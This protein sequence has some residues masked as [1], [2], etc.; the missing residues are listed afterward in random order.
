M[1]RIST[2]RSSSRRSTESTRQESSILSNWAYCAVSVSIP[3]LYAIEVS[4]TT[5]SCHNNPRRTRLVVARADSCGNNSTTSVSQLFSGG[6]SRWWS[7][8]NISAQ[9]RVSARRLGRH[10]N[11]RMAAVEASRP[12]ATPTISAIQSLRSQFRVKN[13]CESS[14]MAAN[15][16]NAKKRCVAGHRK[17]SG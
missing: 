8:G 13:G 9:I 5:A 14:S 6:D 4:E 15:I 7:S 16:V 3:A 1:S 17:E 12:K 10:R 11:K 2:R